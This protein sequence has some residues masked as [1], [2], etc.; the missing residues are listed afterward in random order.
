MIS[1]TAD[2]KEYKLEVTPFTLKQM[3]RSGVNFAQLGE[4]LLGAETLWK[5][6]FIA[7][8]ANVPDS[9]RMEIYNALSMTEDGAEPEYDENGDPVDMLM[10]AVVKQYEDAI[11]SLKRGQ[12]KQGNGSWKMT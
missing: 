7:H 11:M 8:H 6:L 2:G 10:L 3:E 12:G 5:G 4:K 1:F 9:K